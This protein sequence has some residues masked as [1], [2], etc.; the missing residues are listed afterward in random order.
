ML[1]APR[2][3]SAGS[4]PTLPP[5]PRLAIVA[6]LGIVTVALV[7]AVATLTDGT[8]P[9]PAF[10]PAGSELPK[11]AL[12]AEPVLWVDGAITNTNSG[13]RLLLDLAGIEGLD[14]TSIELFEPFDER[15]SEF[16][17]VSLEAIVAA[18][19]PSAGAT[20][21]HLTALDDY[22]VD[23]SLQDVARGGILLATRQSG[24]PIAVDHGGPIRIVFRDG[25]ASGKN[26]DQWIWSVRSISVR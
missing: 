16:T 24:Q 6:V 8:S 11:I 21:L 14:T 4:S 13:E 9:A 19:G 17:G 12:P 2:T 1:T 7:V 15:R 3:T 20:S 26:L 25:V 23:I 22:E 5:R 18:I 10:A